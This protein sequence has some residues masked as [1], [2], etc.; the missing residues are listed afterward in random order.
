M[1]IDLKHEFQRVSNIIFDYILE[2]F[3][4][5]K[6]EEKKD[7]TLIS[8]VD[9][10]ISKI[11][12]NFAQSHNI[13]I[14]DEEHHDKADIG[15]GLVIVSDPLDGS[16]ELLFGLEAF[17]PSLAILKDGE[18]I[19]SHISAPLLGERIDY[20]DNIAK[21]TRYIGT[22]NQNSHIITP[23]TKDLSFGDGAYVYIDPPLNGICGQHKGNDEH[24]LN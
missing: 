22:A 12:L 4:D 10:T 21:H 8:E 23:R 1:E 9:L 16:R 24:I 18:V 11:V 17:G 20:C 14:F 19:C 7:K 5:A 13:G 3:K 6:A 2:K 15:S